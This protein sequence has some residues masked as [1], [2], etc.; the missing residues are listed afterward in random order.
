MHY[1]D[2]PICMKELVE[3]CVRVERMEKPIRMQHHTVQIYTLVATAVSTTA[4]SK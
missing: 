1:I 2:L 4:S 3:K